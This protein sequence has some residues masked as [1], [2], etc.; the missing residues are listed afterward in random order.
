MYGSWGNH[1]EHSGPFDLCSSLNTKADS[2]MVQYPIERSVS[3]TSCAPAFIFLIS[4]TSI[5][6]WGTFFWSIYHV[7]STLTS[8]YRGAHLRKLWSHAYIWRTVRPLEGPGVGDRGVLRHDVCVGLS[9]FGPLPGLHHCGALPVHIL[10]REKKKK[11]SRPH[12]SRPWNTPVKVRRELFSPSWSKARSRLSTAFQIQKWCDRTPSRIDLTETWGAWKARRVG[13]EQGFRRVGKRGGVR[14]KKKRLHS[15]E[16][17]NVD[18]EDEVVVIGASC[19]TLDVIACHLP[20][21]SER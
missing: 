13:G 3:S 1:W 17:G 14:G 20:A 16:A 10:K 19:A 4:I 2:D 15:L 7:S 18:V 5:E 11:P 8:H 12:S 9:R 21:W 6:W